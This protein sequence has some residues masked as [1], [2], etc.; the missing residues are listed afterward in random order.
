M[1]AAFLELV[2][3]YA[4][5]AFGRQLGFAERVG[6]ADWVLDQERRLLV[7]DQRLEFPAQILGS[8]ADHGASWLWAWAN[9]TVEPSMT[10]AVVVLRDVGRRRGVSELTD[11]DVAATR[12]SD[13][14]LMALV[15]SSLLDADAYFRCPYDGGAAFVVV[16]LTGGGQPQE[17]SSVQRVVQTIQAAI[18]TISIAVT[19]DGIRHYLDRVG[20][21]TTETPNELAIHADDAS[22]TLA[23]DSLGRLTSIDA[24]VQTTAGSEAAPRISDEG[25][26]EPSTTV[27][28]EVAAAAIQRVLDY[29]G[30]REALEL[31][32]SDKWDLSREPIDGQRAGGDRQLISDA[33]Q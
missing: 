2:Q 31:S 19:R 4:L 28:G 14:H 5:S 23:F 9:P 15:A 3:T 26:P 29:I 33:P 20:L 1:N 27:D 7:L 16:D 13:P 8:Y 32:V 25:S 17:D 10:E 11:A 30:E 18:T 21:A 24:N 6:N 12:F 22:A